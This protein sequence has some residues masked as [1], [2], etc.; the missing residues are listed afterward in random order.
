[1]FATDHTLQCLLLQIS[2]V[3]WLRQMLTDPDHTDL[4]RLRIIVC[5]RFIQCTTILL[6]GG[7]IFASVY[8][9]VFITLLLVH[10][11]LLQVISNKKYHSKC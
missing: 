2:L 5:V 1:M 4:F 9:I 10:S 6:K 3:R 8:N 7:K 11:T